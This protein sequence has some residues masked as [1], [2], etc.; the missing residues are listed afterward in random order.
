MRQLLHPTAT[1]TSP[2]SSPPPSVVSLPASFF[3]HEGFMGSCSLHITRGC[4][5]SSS[6]PAKSN[7]PPHHQ[8][9]HNRT[10]PKRTKTRMENILLE[11][12]SF[13]PAINLQATRPGSSLYQQLLHKST[14][15]NK[16]TKNHQTRKSSIPNRWV[17]LT[18][19]HNIDSQQIQEP[20]IIIS[21]TSPPPNNP[22]IPNQ[23]DI[24]LLG[25]VGG[26]NTVVNLQQQIQK[27]TTYHQLLHKS[28]TN[29]IN[30]NQEPPI[31][32]VKCQVFP[33]DAW[34]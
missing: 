18:R 16:I 14:T 5:T 9:L 25:K 8:H 23:N 11:R 26:F 17:H 6:S 4:C 15:T 19:Q 29:N 32:R 10:Q 21:S 28:T 34:G 22:K 13:N 30:N 1:I 31:R 24:C 33:K 20:S 2:S 7:K 3:A 12:M 27:P